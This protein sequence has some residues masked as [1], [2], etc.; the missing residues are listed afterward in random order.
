MKTSTK[1]FVIFGFTHFLH[2]LFTAFINPLL[3]VLKM[4]HNLSYL[5]M[6]TIPLFMRIP[7]ALSPI[8]GLYGDRV[9]LRI[10]AIVFPLVTAGAILG[11]TIAPNFLTIA[12]LLLIAGFS[13]QIFHISLP[14]LV[15]SASDSDTGFGMSLFMVGGEAARATGPLVV[16][17]IIA[18]MGMRGLLI[19]FPLFL[20]VMIP[21]WKTVLSIPRS[22]SNKRVDSIS[23]SLKKLGKLKYLFF[24]IWGVLV[25]RSFATGVFTAFLPSLLLTRDVPLWMSG[26]SL[27]LVAASSIVGIIISGKLSD[28]FGRRVVI[29][30]SLLISPLFMAGIILFSGWLSIPFIILYG[31]TAY[32]TTPVLLALVQEIS[33]EIPVFA[34]SL[35]MAFSFLMG[36]ATIPLMGLLADQKNLQFALMTSSILSL[37]GIPFL[38]FLK[39][40]RLSVD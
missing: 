36:A 4:N 20:M 18:I 40:S 27:G 14:V 22:S 37:V 25:G 30:G 11:V 19:T 8:I 12:I 13:S 24:G 33:D 39:T 9:D 21:L 17:G 32:S 34:T 23:D 16:M 31:I 28:M 26:S 5:M 15:K 3:P 29:L 7:A 35:F 38:L 1:L 2:D 6:G 10:P